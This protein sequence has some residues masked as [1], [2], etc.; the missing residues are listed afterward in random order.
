MQ[1]LQDIT[2]SQLILGGVDF[3]IAWLLVYAVLK[4]LQTNIRAVQIV[5][6]VFVICFLNLL[7]QFLELSLISVLIED[8]MTWGIIAIVIIFQPEIRTGLEQMGRKSAMKRDGQLRREAA[9]VSELSEAVKILS[10]ERTGALIV[11]EN[12]VP[13]MELSELATPLD[14]IVTS[15]LVR[16]IFRNK[17]PLHD[18]AVIIRDAKI[19]CAGAILPATTRDDLPQTTGTRHRAAIGVS[20]MSDSVTIVVSEE[21][22]QIS[23]TNGGKIERYEKH[24]HFEQALKKILETGV[25]EG[26]EEA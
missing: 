15:E 8:V 25:V 26:G 7:S 6:G 23:I 1:F 16:T 4:L 5:K 12:T 17:T 10:E 24:F 11:L 21:T 20:E 13:L 19:A 22:G 9:W 3:Y 2:L 14:A 18:G